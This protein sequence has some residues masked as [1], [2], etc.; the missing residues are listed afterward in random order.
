M[1]GGY[2]A[3]VA[4]A[5]LAFALIEAAAKSFEPPLPLAGPSLPA[6]WISV[7]IALVMATLLVTVVAMPALLLCLAVS[8]RMD[9]RHPT[10][11]VACG[12]A[13]GF[14]LGR[15]FAGPVDRSVLAAASGAVGGAVHW[16][17]AVR[18]VA[19]RP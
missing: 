2:L 3:S 10:I 13:I 18:G 15:L 5:V 6:D 8:V 19:G 11:H 7:A 9:W 14:A 17:L 1:L 4:V 12:V 16:R